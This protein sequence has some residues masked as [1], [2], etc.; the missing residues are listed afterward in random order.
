MRCYLK[1]IK[2]VNFYING[3][4][5]PMKYDQPSQEEKIEESSCLNKF[6]QN[7]QDI[8]SELIDSKQ[9]LR[10]IIVGEDETK[11]MADKKQGY[12]QKM[13]SLLIDEI[14]LPL[15]K[16]EQEES[17]NAIAELK[18]DNL[19]IVFGYPLGYERATAMLVNREE[20]LV[21]VTTKKGMTEK[22]I[23]YAYWGTEEYYR[24]YIKDTIL[25]E[26][27]ILFNTGADLFQAVSQGEIEGML[28][29]KSTY[30]SYLQ[31]EKEL[32]LVSSLEFPVQE[33]IL[34]SNKQEALSKFMDKFLPFYEDIL[35]EEQISTVEVRYQ[36]PNQGA[37]ESVILW[38]AS[39]IMG[40]VFICIIFCFVVHQ[41]KKKKK[42][43]A[44]SILYQ[45]LIALHDKSQE[46]LVVDLLAGK[47]RSNQ[48]FSCL[49]ENQK[50]LPRKNMRLKELS[51][52]I[53]F[54]FEEHY[55]YISRQFERT[56]LFQYQLYLGG[57]RYLIKEE[58]VFEQGI[59]VIL[60]S[61]EMLKE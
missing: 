43:Q 18:E 49:F 28:I 40:L 19:S 35:R 8:I 41:W 1:S 3:G 36:E 12:Y 11:I 44:A 25:E 24:S 52:R 39:V 22:E 60:M 7:N 31:E 4:S 27:T 13:V 26:H 14:N 10:Y 46:K 30:E 15:Q 56:Y 29:K 47:V 51:N 33:Y 54:D 42:K 37:R 5:W 61:K 32:Y 20:S 45:E 16:V 48:N 58:G 23:P 6:I 55:R 2:K 9:Q 38:T 50:S 34:I 21:L 59:F 53:G 57:V 17:V